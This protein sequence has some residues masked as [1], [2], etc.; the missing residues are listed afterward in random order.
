MLK[1]VWGPGG[2]ELYTKDACTVGSRTRRRESPHDTD[3][4]MAHGGG[5]ERRPIRPSVQ[6]IH[7][8]REGAADMST[9]NGRQGRENASAGGWPW[10][11]VR[12]RRGKLEEVDCG[13]WVERR[14]GGRV[15]Y[16]WC[17]G[18]APPS[19]S[20]GGWAGQT[21]G[22]AGCRPHLAAGGGGG[23]GTSPGGACREMA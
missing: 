10:T 12:S 9:G 15:W 7:R 14:K 3:R 23:G 16:G 19:L 6:S 4:P 22:T 2:E 5:G 18:R 17:G 11:W 21:P 20:C 1:R 13:V 8:A